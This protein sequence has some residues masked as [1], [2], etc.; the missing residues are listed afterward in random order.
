ML[1]SLAVAALALALLLPAGAQQKSPDPEVAK[2]VERLLRSAPPPDDELLV[3]AEVLRIAGWT[4][5][6]QAARRFAERR[7]LAHVSGAAAPRYPTLGAA[8]REE[9]QRGR[10]AA[11][12]LL[13]FRRRV[14]EGSIALLPADPAAPF[15]RSFRNESRAPIKAARAFIMG[16]GGLFLEC[17]M[18]ELTGG[19]DPIASGAVGPLRCYKREEE[20]AWRRLD[21]AMR[22]LMPDRVF[23]KASTT[24]LHFAAP[25]FVVTPDAVGPVTNVASEASARLERAA[26]VEKY[27]ASLNPGAATKPESAPKPPPRTPEQMAADML[28]VYLIAIGSPIALGLLVGVPIGARAARPAATARAVLVAVGVIAF[29]AIAVVG[30]PMFGGLN[31]GNLEGQV[32]AIFLGVGFLAGLVMAFLA[33]GLF[34]TGLIIGGLFGTAFRKRG[35]LPAT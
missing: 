6:A 27:V 9:A 5:E 35:A 8:L 23:T 19:K 26:P 22:P 16:E 30:L 3:T 31:M 32:G 17:E 24:R 15:T 28:R 20:D 25:G 11:Q 29:F 4:D 12:E 7:L 21:N 18:E 13:E 10:A 34:A 33:W 14:L 2:Y 1:R